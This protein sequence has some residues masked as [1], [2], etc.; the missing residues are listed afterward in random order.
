VDLP[1]HML[2]AQ[3]RLLMRAHNIVIVTDLT[4]P[5]LRD[6][7]RIRQYLRTLRPDFMPLIVA[8]RVGDTA[9]ATVDVAAFEKNLEAKLDMKI[10]EDVKDAKQA[11]NTGKAL[12]TITPKAETTKSI[13]ALA[14]I[15]TGIAVEHKPEESKGFLKTLFGSSETSAKPAA[16]TESKKA[17]KKIE[18]KTKTDA[19]PETKPA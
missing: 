6:T 3:K 16:K 17:D 2:P 18:H 4:L 10:P 12:V 19:K 11:A 7:R 15:L 8:N 5:G 13:I 14:H 9:N 1:R